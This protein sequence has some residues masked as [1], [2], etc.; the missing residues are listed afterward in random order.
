M[1]KAGLP[2]VVLSR[3]V[4][5]ASLLAFALARRVHVYQNITRMQQLDAAVRDVTAPHPRL[6]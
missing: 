1:K 5:W 2:L 6:L 4:R 3:P